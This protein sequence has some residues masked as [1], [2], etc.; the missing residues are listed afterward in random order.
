MEQ[1]IA[2]I[3]SPSHP[4][5]V[6]FAQQDAYI[7]TFAQE[8][9]HL[10]RDILIN[11]ELSTKRAN[12]IVAV[13]SGAV[14]GVFTPTEEDC[15]QESNIDQINEFI[16]VIDCSGSMQDEN[17]IGLA[18][19]AM[20]L[21]LKSLPLDCHFNIIRFGSVYKTLFTDI[22]TIY[23]ED[24]ARIAEKLINEIQ[25]DLGGTELMRPLQWIEQHLPSEGRA[26]QLFLL[27]DGEI[28]NVTEV[29]DLCRSMA[30]STRI[31]S[32]GL[33][34]SPS[35][36]LVKGLARS[37]NGRFVFIPPNANVDIYVGEQLQK[38][39][40]S[41]ITNV[42]V[43]WNLGIQVEN[44]PRKIPPVYANDRLIVYALS[45]D[46]IIPFDQN[47]SVELRTISNHRSLGIAKV[48]RIPNIDENQTIARLAAKALILELQHDKD[49]SFNGKKSNIGS[50]QTQFQQLNTTTE[51]TAQV[52]SDKQTNKE[53]IIELSLKYNILSP[54]T[55]FIGVEKRTNTSN[56]QMVLREVPIEI[57]ADDQHLY[58]R[59]PRSL[60][61][62]RS[63]FFTLS[64]CKRAT[65]FT[66]SSAYNPTAINSA[67]Y[68]SLLMCDDIEDELCSAMPM[69][70]IN[71]L[72]S[73]SASIN[74]QMNSSDTTKPEDDSELLLE[75]ERWANDAISVPQ[76][77][78]KD[79]VWP[80]N[81]EDIVRYLINKQNFDGLWNSDSTII[82]RLTGKP[83]STFQSINT[84][85]DASILTSLIIILII[86]TRFSTYSSLWHGVMQKARKRINT[87]LNN[88][89]A[90]LETLFENIRQQL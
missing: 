39:L 23:N 21:F 28:S 15:R 74:L 25:A 9:T 2:R 41:C 51:E 56:D 57:S 66:L 79:D 30:T 53:R 52:I 58:R 49:S 82:Q 54:H 26:R 18:R 14:M 32:F 76:F 31:F 48:D 73:A 45:N 65:G 13:E 90:N 35:R 87:L 24:N 17:K 72:K 78:K 22:T 44:A 29:L 27:T 67:N 43:Q 68:S 89:S 83:L 59:S 85:I 42:D 11:I 33:G 81:D 19:Q 69:A 6:D 16:F 77:P 38:A 62:A 60:A 20:L 80:S 63:K 34:H 8:N 50:V 64:R 3:N 84:E 86:E 88:D 40:Q 55:A 36:S 12:T 47:S 4:I 5:Q 71:C 70:T 37:T 46:K 75:L 10:D 7:V 61:S 1:Y